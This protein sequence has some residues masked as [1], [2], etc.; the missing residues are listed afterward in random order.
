MKNKDQLKGEREYWKT[1][2]TGFINKDVD[3]K[4]HRDS[5]SRDNGIIWSTM[6]L[7]GTVRFY[8]NLFA[9]RS[10]ARYVLVF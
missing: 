9:L 1:M 2:K 8:T 10:Y 6:G 5:Q 4:E 3:L 7:D